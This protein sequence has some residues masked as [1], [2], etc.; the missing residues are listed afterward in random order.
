LNAE[1]ALAEIARAFE[2]CGVEAVLI[3][4]AAAALQGAPVTTLDFDFM[5][6]KTPANL[7]KLKRLAHLLGGQILKPYYPLSDLYRVMIDER[8]LQLDFMP[9]VHGI[10][11]F[12]GL[13]SRAS[14][15][16]FGSHQLWVAD[17][18][19]VI[20]SKRALGRRKDLASLDILERTQDE[21]AKAKNSVQN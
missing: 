4:N 20:R 19:D 1:P 15:V 12:A 14:R 11:S 7:K 10:K 21:K 13:R 9:T 18:R 6:R 16:S 5:F 17:L 3:G 2:E 8:G